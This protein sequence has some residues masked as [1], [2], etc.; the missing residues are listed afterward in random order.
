MGP[1]KIQITLKLCK[2]MAES[3]LSEF[4]L[5]QGGRDP[6][7]ADSDLNLKA[8]RNWIVEYHKDDTHIDF[9]KSYEA[10]KEAKRTLIKQVFKEIFG[11][12]KPEW[13]NNYD[14]KAFEEEL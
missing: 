14:P 4:N 3:M 1:P 9:W 6:R 10:R 7:L 11:E 8:D 12:N 2:E 5:V 13:K